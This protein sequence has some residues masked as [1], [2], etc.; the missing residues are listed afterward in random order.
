MKSW[1]LTRS[2]LANLLPHWWVGKGAPGKTGPP[3]TNHWG[4]MLVRG[5]LVI[6][7]SSGLGNPV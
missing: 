3:L 1:T 5:F 6:I 4:L 2:A 7:T